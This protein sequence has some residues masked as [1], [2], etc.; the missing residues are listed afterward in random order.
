MN[1]EFCHSPAHIW[2]DC[3]KKPVGWKPARLATKSANR[4]SG[5]A[6]TD[7]LP[8]DGSEARVGSGHSRPTKSTAAR[9]DVLTNGDR[10]VDAPAS[11]K[12]SVASSGLIQIGGSD[13]RGKQTAI[14]GTQ[15][16]PVDT[17]P[18]GG[19]RP[20]S[21]PT[22]AGAVE[23]IDRPKFD[24]KAWMREY[25]RVYMRNHRAKK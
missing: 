24:K 14:A 4:K 9:K 19:V 13:V 10:S 3:P 23:D 17:N 22:L 11:S 15:A 16:L 12:R 7:G 2:F 21:T 5:I 8:K 20:L 18:G 6:S 1:C 25:M